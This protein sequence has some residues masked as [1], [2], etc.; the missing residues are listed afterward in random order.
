[1]IQTAPKVDKVQNAMYHDNKSAHWAFRF[2]D[3][4][5]VANENKFPYIFSEEGIV[6]LTNDATADNA[7][8]G[9]NANILS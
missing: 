8:K 7:E 5:N 6:Y 2:K 4:S 3:S 1:V 9:S